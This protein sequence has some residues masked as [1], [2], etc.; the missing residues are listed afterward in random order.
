MNKQSRH[1]EVLKHRIK[2]RNIIDTLGL[3]LSLAS[4]VLILLNGL[5][6]IQLKEAIGVKQLLTLLGVVGILGVV[7]YR[8]WVCPNCDKSLRFSK[9]KS[10]FFEP[11]PQHC[12]NCSYDLYALLNIQHNFPE[13][14]VKL[15]PFSRH[16]IILFST[17][18]L[19]CFFLVKVD[20]FTVEDLYKKILPSIGLFSLILI[21]TLILAK[22]YACKNCGMP[23][24][25]GKFCRKCGEQV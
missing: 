11:L 22:V 12:P 5:G 14:R 8:I 24:Q 6:Y 19:L 1:V 9:I 18:G 7:R 4:F 15:W 2:T 17:L 20:F 13:A 21:I 3:C 23:F 16:F 10:N 25:R